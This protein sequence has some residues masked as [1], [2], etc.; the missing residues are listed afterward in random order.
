[1]HESMVLPGDLSNVVRSEMGLLYEEP[2]IGMMLVSFTCVV[3]IMLS[4]A[5]VYSCVG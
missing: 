3:S 2:R 1:M 4:R 5:S